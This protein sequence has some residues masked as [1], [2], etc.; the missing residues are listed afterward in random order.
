VAV[1]EHVPLWD[2]ESWRH[3]LAVV[4]I[5]GVVAGAGLLAQKAVETRPSGAL[6]ACHTARQI[7]PRTYVAAPKMC[8]DPS[9]TYIADFVTSHGK[10]SVTLQPVNDPVTV[11]NFVVLATNGFYNGLAFWRVDTWFTQAGDPQGDGRGGPGY[12]LPDEPSTGAWSSGAVGMARIPGGRV[13]GSQFFIL[14]DK[15]P[16]GGPPA[17]LTYNRFG[18]LKS[19][20]E[21]VN[22]LTN[23][24]RIIS[25]SVRAA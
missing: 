22:A 16:N 15:W 19:G 8:I 17:G 21:V 14:K 4:V 23:E 18:T 11:N 5:L 20:Q 12:F 24:D 6:A 25:I 13:N 3:L 9:R 10:F 2:R 7:A 1:E